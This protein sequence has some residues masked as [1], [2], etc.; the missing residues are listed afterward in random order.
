MIHDVIPDRFSCLPKIGIILLRKHSPGQQ[1]EK[2]LY[3][4]R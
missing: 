2:F 3:N 4:P 1:I